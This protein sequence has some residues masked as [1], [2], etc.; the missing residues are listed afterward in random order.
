[1]ESDTR[2]PRSEQT[3]HQR[4]NA[5]ERSPGGSVKRAREMAGVDRSL[6]APPLP[7]ASRSLPASSNQSPQLDSTSHSDPGSPSVDR[8]PPQRPPR[9]NYVPADLN[10]WGEEG[11]DSLQSFSSA[12]RPSTTFS[13]STASIPEFPPIPDFPPPSY[14][15][16]LRRNLGPPPSARRG[17]SSYY[18]QHPSFIPPIAE[19]R[20]DKHSSYASS[21]A[22]PERGW[23][24][25]APR[26]YLQ[27]GISE[28]DEE[29]YVQHGSEPSSGRQSRGSDYSDSSRLVKPSRNKTLQPFMETIESGDES[30]S[31]SSRSTM[32]RRDL[33]WQRRQE[34]RLRLG[35]PGT[36]GIGR[37]HF[38]GQGN[39]HHPYSGYAS[40]VTFLDSPRSGSPLYNIPKSDPQSR[41]S[42]VDPTMQQIMSHLEKG[43][44]L[45]SSAGTSKRT[46]RATSVV[47]IV[48]KPRLRPPPLNLSP[49]KN[50]SS[51]TVR[52]SASS[53]PELIRRAT[54]LASNLDRSKTESRVGVQDAMQKREQEKAAYPQQHSHTKPSNK[55]D[56]TISDIL[57]AFPSPSTTPSPDPY[58]A[59]EWG[60]PSTVR[61]KSTL[62]R[63]Q[64]IDYTSHSRSHPHSRQTQRQPPKRRCCG[65][66]P[67]AF[68]LL[69]IIILLLMAAAI[70]IPITL[71]V[72]PRNRKSGPSLASCTKSDPCSNAGSSVILNNTCSCICAGGWTGKS[73]TIAPSGDCTTTALPLAS[74]T[75]NYND[76]TVGSSL[77]RLISAASSSYSVPLLGWKLA[78][79]FS[80]NE[81]ACSAQNSLVT[82]ANQGTRSRLRLR[83]L[84]SLLN[85]LPSTVL[86]GRTQG[87]KVLD[88]RAE[89]QSSNGILFAGSPTDD[90]NNNASPTSSSSSSPSPSSSS[91]SSNNTTTTTT[92]SNTSSNG[93]MTP[94]TDTVRNFARTG[95]LFILQETGSVSAAGAVMRR[96]S[97]TLSGGSFDGTRLVTWST[98]EISGTGGSG[99]GNGGIGGVSIDLK[100]F[101]IAWGNGT[102]VGGRAGLM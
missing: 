10:Y 22:I 98:A 80:S 24:G 31:Q 12:S 16:P 43:G 95:I 78:A 73:C 85:P 8:A 50:R 54:R 13:D 47:T 59:R 14:P 1:M 15:A 65:M 66:P 17:A 88:A 99:G 28:E 41:S 97:T 62:S 83:D 4:S 55:A 77:P 19:E 61:G 23:D 69:I 7:V 93:D 71:I 40:D 79:L 32:P 68:F 76:A 84:D 36:D 100:A 89:A 18:S 75:G 60:T 81:L 48:E 53:L 56:G 5:G 96:L 51:T 91:S 42:P 6:E 94:V 25:E 11:R 67:W 37:H 20:S 101:T 30:A 26:I 58:K 38:M 57:N 52:S 82:L 49:P 44:A 90:N 27:S 9:P 34:E 92:T 2:Q 64:T 39:I 3:N 35:A 86:Q 46:S 29:E 72:V 70:T 45:A 87:T 74:G 63:S 33:D 102:I 21:D